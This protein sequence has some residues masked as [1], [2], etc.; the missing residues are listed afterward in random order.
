[1]D[2]GNSLISVLETSR[3]LKCFILQIESGNSIDC[4][5]FRALKLLN[6]QYRFNTSITVCNS[7]DST[8]ENAN[9]TSVQEMRFRWRILDALST[10]KSTSKVNVFYF[11]TSNVRSCIL[12]LVTILYSFLWTSWKKEFASK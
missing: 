7:L 5:D 12:Q 9:S 4:R 11:E 8:S 6:F 3:Y 1:M 2:S 10:T